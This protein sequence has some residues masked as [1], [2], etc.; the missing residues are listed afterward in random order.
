M[1]ASYETVRRT[2]VRRVTNNETTK[3]VIAR[4]MPARDAKGAWIS[5]QPKPVKTNGPKPS[6]EILGGPDRNTEFVLVDGI[7]PRRLAEM[8]VTIV[9]TW[10]PA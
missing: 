2:T 10:Q 4:P 9:A 1:N 6:L 3:P 8:L 5:A 7:L